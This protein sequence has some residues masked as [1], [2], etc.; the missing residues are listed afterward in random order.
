MGYVARERFN[1]G[2]PHTPIPKVQSVFDVAIIFLDQRMIAG[3]AVVAGV[4]GLAVIRRR[5]KARPLLRSKA[6]QARFS[7]LGTVYAPK[8]YRRS[9]RARKD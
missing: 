8:Q 1:M 4:I 9:N 7:H 2:F 5:R 3:L 6:E